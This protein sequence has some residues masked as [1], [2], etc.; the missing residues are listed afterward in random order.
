MYCNFF[1]IHNTFFLKKWWKG[2]KRF[3]FGHEFGFYRGP[4]TILSKLLYSCTL[5]LNKYAANAK[6]ATV[7]G[8]IPAS[9]DTVES[10]GRQMKQY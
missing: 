6:V 3:N 8:A 10:K 7:L 9:S 4:Y 1:F 5:L 2:L